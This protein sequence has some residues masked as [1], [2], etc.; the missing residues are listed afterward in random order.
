M[1]RLIGGSLHGSMS[2]PSNSRVPC[3]VRIVSRRGIGGAFAPTQR[4]RAHRYRKTNPPTCAALPTSI[5]A[6]VAALGVNRVY[7]APVKLREAINGG[8]SHKLLVVKT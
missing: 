2:M 3:A 6:M 4:W 7:S 8:V 1:S 5:L